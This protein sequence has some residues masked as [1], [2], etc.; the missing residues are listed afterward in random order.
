MRPKRKAFESASTSKGR[1]GRP[2]G[3][4]PRAPSM[5]WS[6]RSQWHGAVMV[7]WY[8]HCGAEFDEAA[9]QIVSQVLELINRL[10]AWSWPSFS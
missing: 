10:Q 1:P 7:L 4:G 6:S 9:L 5:T 8:F 3:S 2:S